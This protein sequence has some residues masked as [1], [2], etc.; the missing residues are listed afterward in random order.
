MKR[1]KKKDKLREILGKD[2]SETVI[3]KQ[4]ELTKEV[5]DGKKNY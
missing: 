4:D 2:I 1:P 5:R 3:S